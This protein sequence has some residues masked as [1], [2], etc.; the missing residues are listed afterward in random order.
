[1]DRGRVRLFGVLVVCPQCVGVLHHD[2]HRAGDLACKPTMLRLSSRACFRE[3]LCKSVEKLEHQPSVALIC[4][5]EAST[6][7][8]MIT[9]APSRTSACRTFPD[10]STTAR[11]SKPATSFSHSTALR[12][13]L[14]CKYGQICVAIPRV[15]VVNRVVASLLT[16]TRQE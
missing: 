6:S 2:I 12:A 1:M 9:A 13:S 10:S 8:S 11:V 7:D 14:K 16:A 3:K 15:L 4:P 5:F